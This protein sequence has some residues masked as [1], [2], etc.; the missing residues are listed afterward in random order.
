MPYP[1]VLMWDDHVFHPSRKVRPLELRATLSAESGHVR[2]LRDLHARRSG[3]G[4]RADAWWW[5]W[6]DGVQLDFMGN[7]VGGIFFVLD[8]IIYDKVLLT[9][10]AMESLKDMSVE[11]QFIVDVAICFY[12]GGALVSYQPSSASFSAKFC[13]HTHTHTR[14]Q[15]AKTKNSHCIGVIFAI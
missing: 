2:A 7:N 10:I 4:R 13:T 3:L 8:G 5:W 9:E 14:P 6:R 11:N 15:K 1:P 12:F